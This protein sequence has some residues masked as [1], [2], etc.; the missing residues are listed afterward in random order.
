MPMAMN[1]GIPL[2]VWTIRPDHWAFGVTNYGF[3]T[4]LVPDPTVEENASAMRH[5]PRATRAHA[6]L[7]NSVQ[8]LI[9]G[10]AKGRNIGPYAAYIAAGLRGD[11]GDAWSTPAVCLWSHRDLEVTPVEGMPQIGVASLPLGYPLVAIDGETQVAAI[12][13]LVNDPEAFG[14][15]DEVINTQVPFELHWNISLPDARQIFHDRNLRAVSVSKTLALS[16]DQRDLATNIAD[17]AVSTTEVEVDGRSQVL[18]R[19]VNRTKRQLNRADPEWLTLSSVRS[20]AVT[21]MLGKSGIEHT[22][23]VL[24]EEDLPEGVDPQQAINEVADI[25]GMVFRRFA[26]EFEARSAITAPAVLAGL[27]AVAHHV[28]S[29]VEGAQLE[30]EDLVQLLAEVHWEREAKYW[31]GVAAKPTAS[32]GLSFAGGVKDSAYRVY[33]ALLNDSSELGK[34]IRGRN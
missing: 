22:S 29:W 7:R 6:E 15:T 10:T 4:T 12:H 17:R 16:M 24:A 11:Y 34:R 8:R 5:Q 28:T 27:G 2:N 32:G 14:L 26:D 33:D 21:V 9:K 18:N 19:F 3:L 23:G 31:E 25:M 1:Q 20:L 13:R 30:R